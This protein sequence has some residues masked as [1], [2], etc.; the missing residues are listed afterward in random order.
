[1]NDYFV[2]RHEDA[3]KAVLGTALVNDN[4]ARTIADLDDELFLGEK[5][6]QLHKAIKQLIAR[7]EPT[8]LTTV[9]PL[10][11]K[12]GYFSVEGGKGWSPVE[13]ADLTDHAR[14]PSYLPAGIKL[15][16]ATHNQRKLRDI[17]KEAYEKTNSRFLIDYEIEELSDKLQ[18]AAY[19]MT[20]DLQ[21]RDTL[22][23]IS[24]PLDSVYR[25][26]LDHNERD[27]KLGL[28]TGITRLDQ[29]TGGLRPGDMT[30]IGARPS[31]GKT[32]L[33][34]TITLNAALSGKT[35]LIL[36]LEMSQNQ[37]AQRA[38]ASKSV[39]DLR[40]IRNCQLD[41]REKTIIGEKVNQLS[42]APL[43]V[44]DGFNITTTYMKNAAIRV[45]KMAEKPVDLIVVDYIQLASS[46]Q[47]HRSRE[48]EIASISRSM[49]LLAKDLG[50]HVIL[51]SQLNRG[52]ETRT[53]KRPIL[54][55]FRE[56]GAIEQDADL[57][58]GLYRP[59]VYTA[60]S[61]DARKAEGIILK[62]RNGPIGVIDLYWVSETATFHNPEID[63]AEAKLEAL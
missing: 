46:S 24:K 3:E 34:T 50:C 40:L 19:E 48:Q 20:G 11:Q 15:L 55:D 25:E 56:S 49:K 18:S 22:A 47:R 51:L 52:L 12:Q 35:C 42:K 59:Y 61:D 58:I 29:M 62:H 14:V 54:A 21:K 5:H 13:L 53:D 10:L 27:P 16:K 43:Y 57:A 2:L 32:A 36:S 4:A 45:T 39:I 7:G 28:K 23:H 63:Y 26:I 44:D 60:K 9:L 30:V 41:E 17:A 38:L 6:K 31:M 37:L 33:A 8:D 1:M